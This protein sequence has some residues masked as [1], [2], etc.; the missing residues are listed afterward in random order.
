MR[1]GNYNFIF[2]NFIGQD[3]I[4]L[5]GGVIE[6]LDAFPVDS[7][8]ISEGFYDRF[9]GGKPGGVMRK[10]VAVIQGIGDFFGAKDPFEEV[11]PPVINRIL[12]TADLNNIDTAT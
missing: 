4:G 2:G 1:H 6:D 5:T 7:P 11:I 12:Y 8:V 9:L 10:R 3:T